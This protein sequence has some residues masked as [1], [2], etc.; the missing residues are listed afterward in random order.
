[1]NRCGHHII[2]RV[3]VAP[4]AL[5]VGLSL[6]PLPAA[7]QV[8]DDKIYSFILFDQLEYRTGGARPVS[9]DMVGWVGGDFT[10]FWIKSEGV[11][12]TTGGGGDAEAQGLYSRL[13]APFWEVQAG[14]RLDARYGDG[15]DR[16]RVL[17]VFGF[18][19]LAPYWFDIEPVLFVSQDG[20]L[21]ARLTASYDMFFTQRL[22]AQ[23]Q[24]EANVA[25]QEV[26]EFG[27]G[28]GFND[29]ELGVRLRYE[30]RREYAPYV[31]VS[32][33]R[34]F[35]GTAGLARL[36]GDAVSDVAA[37]GGLRVWF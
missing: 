25:V 24:F 19:G 34:R 10:R 22:I 9:W 35:A 7:A 14:L 23:P 13:I 18:E 16:I 8:M 29:I 27:V 20:D 33:L 1:M 37:V 5:M 30:I 12:A 11:Q 17:G 3:A 32:W 28:S 31:G 15:E 36:A 2:R 26:V 6:A 4:A 21:S